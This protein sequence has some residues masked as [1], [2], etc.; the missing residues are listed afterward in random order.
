MVKHKKY[1]KQHNDLQLDMFCFE[2]QK[3]LIQADVIAQG[4]VNEWVP[5]Q[6]TP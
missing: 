1:G 2:W 4:E 5:I 3:F 6:N